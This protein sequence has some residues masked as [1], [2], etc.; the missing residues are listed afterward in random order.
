MAKGK[1]MVESGF[2]TVAPWSGLAKCC[3]PA[4]AL[5][6]ASEMDRL[7]PGPVTPSWMVPMA[8]DVVGLTD[9]L[10]CRRS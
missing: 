4:M 10:K 8:A 9:W 5:I 3:D 2:T 7:G 1:E 6:Q